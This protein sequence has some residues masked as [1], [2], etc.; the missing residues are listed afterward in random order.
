VS[1]A[2]LLALY[3][4]SVL[5]AG[6]AYLA[7]ADASAV[8]ATLLCLG[9]A[10]ALALGEVLDPS[11]QPLRDR[12][13]YRLRVWSLG[14]L[15]ALVVMAL[16]FAAAAPRP[17]LLAK[18]VELLLAAHFVFLLLPGLGSGRIPTLTTSMSLATLAAFRGGPLAAIA[19][20]SYLTGLGS[21]LVFDHYAARL[22]ARPENEAR[23]LGHALREAAAFV[24]P[25]AAP[26]ALLLA[27]VPPRPHKNLAA[28]MFEGL[29]PPDKLAAAYLQ[30]AFASLCGAAFVYY[31]TRLLKR[32]R[33]A[34]D[35][36]VE[37]VDV[38]ARGD[39]ALPEKKP[40]GRRSYTGR[41][42]AIVRAYVRF[43][44]QAA[45]LLLVRRVDQTP[46][47][48]AGLVRAPRAPLERLTELF[49][50]ARYGPDEPDDRAVADADR[51]SADLLAWLHGL[52]EGAKRGR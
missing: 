4:L 25:V 8:A 31:A 5:P 38:E 26:L 27:L 28:N 52:P 43:L 33:R 45:G 17:D 50:A 7:F 3:A 6:C 36:V 40:R 51:S 9:I 32:K 1:A 34:Q 44:A 18:E 47:E 21:F 22:A 37:N 30:L 23:L 42:G 10:A 41:R 12:A 35:P 13:G 11:L 48:I 15:A 24:L 29:V 16:G 49:M 14:A 19:S 46:R 39:E 2:R 20:V